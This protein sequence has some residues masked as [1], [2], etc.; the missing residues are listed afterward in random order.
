MFGGLNTASIL[1]GLLRDVFF[2]GSRMK[3]FTADVS[4]HYCEISNMSPN[5]SSS[6]KQVT[7]L[8]QQINVSLDHAVVSF[9]AMGSKEPRPLMQM[10]HIAG[11]TG[12]L[13]DTDTR[14]RR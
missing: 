9:S 7:S 6:L 3:H 10:L 12:S 2:Q 11:M 13:C 8:V 1:V 4:H 14:R 5:K